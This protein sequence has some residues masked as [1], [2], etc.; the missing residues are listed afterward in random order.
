MEDLNPETNNINPENS[1]PVAEIRIS[2]I[3]GKPVF[4]N[5]GGP[6]LTSDA[7]AILLKEVEEQLRIIER[8]V[9][10][11]RDVDDNLITDIYTHLAGQFL[12][13]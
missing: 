13:E 12:I 11:I 2:E 8:M 6:D 4:M 5:F 7:G 3:N 1:S 10:V 9:R